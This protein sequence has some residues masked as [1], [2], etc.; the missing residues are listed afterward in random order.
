MIGERTDCTIPQGSA[1][2]T[3]HGSSWTQ[4]IQ[5]GRLTVED[6][7]A[8]GIL[9]IA[10]Y[11][12]PDATFWLRAFKMCQRVIKNWITHLF[13]STLLKMASNH[14]GESHYLLKAMFWSRELTGTDFLAVGFGDVGKRGAQVR[15]LLHESRQLSGA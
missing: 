5:L 12:D 2:P 14:Q 13:S 4:T 15:V 3:Q 9:H 11:R 8:Q 6:L 7:E 1:N 10:F